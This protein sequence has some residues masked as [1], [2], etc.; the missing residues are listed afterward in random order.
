[1]KQPPP[2]PLCLGLTFKPYLTAEDHTVSHET[3]TVI[4]CTNCKFL[5][6]YPVPPRLSDYYL[7]DG[8]ISHADRA[9]TV[10]ACLYK[11]VRQFTLRWK[12]SLINKYYSGPSKKLLDYGC[13]T[14]TF[15]EYSNQNGW[16]A[17]GI[18]PSPVARKIAAQVSETNV[19]ASLDE[20]GIADY[21]VITLWHVLEHVSDLNETLQLLHSKL[22]NAGMMFIAVPNYRSPDAMRYKQLWAAYDVPR[23]LWHFSQDT[24]QRLLTAHGFILHATVPLKL[25]AFYV[26]I[27]SEQ[28]KRRGKT[29]PLTFFKGIINGLKSN[30][31][32]IKYK[33]YSSLIYIVR[34]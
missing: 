4:Q 32:A 33:D 20:T 2:C 7:S 31:S 12:H 23:H 24:M 34:K 10:I 19:V 9:S 13:G 16:S 25:D 22:S 29:G 1:M 27:L 5:L 11:I 28:Y 18:E 21:D 26:C 6:T 15:L 17:T 30:W 3:F 14:G 8:Y